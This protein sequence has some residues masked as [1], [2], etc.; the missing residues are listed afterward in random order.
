MIIIITSIINVCLAGSCQKHTHV[1][2][3]RQKKWTHFAEEEARTDPC[4]FVCST[5]LFRIMTNIVFITIISVNGVVFFFSC[6]LEALYARNFRCTY[7]YKLYYMMSVIIYFM[8]VWMIIMIILLRDEWLKFVW[9]NEKLSL[10]A[11][12]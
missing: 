2:M 5:L 9:M 11:S 10:H 7:T 3:H 6:Y 8:Y 1:W 12:T 4:V